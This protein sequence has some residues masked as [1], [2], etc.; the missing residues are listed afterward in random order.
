MGFNYQQPGKIKKAD[1]V[2]L[3]AAIVVVGALIAWALFGGS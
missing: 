2:L 1:L 3:A